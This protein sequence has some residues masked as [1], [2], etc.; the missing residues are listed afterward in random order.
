[1]SDSIKTYRIRTEVGNTHDAVIHVPLKQTYDMLEILSLKLDQSKSYK[2]YTS[3]YGVVVGR[4]QANDA[5]GI[6][7]CK[8]SVFIAYDEDNTDVKKSILYHYSSVQSTDN[9]GVR[10]NLLPD[11]L[12]EA[13]H[14]NVGTFPNKRLILDNKDELEIF[15]EYWKYTTVT[16]E[17]GDYMLYGVPT[18]SQQ[19]HI[20]VD[21]SDIGIWS[22]KPTDMVY[23]G[24]NINQF[25]SP[26][27]FK[28]SKNLNSLSQIYTQD[29]GLYVYPYWGETTENSDIIGITR[30]DINIDYKFEPTCIFMGSIIT[31]SGNNAIGK[32]CAGDKRLGKMANLTT[33]EG[34]IEMIRKTFDN[35]VEQIRIK[36]DRVINGD[37]VW[38][39]QIPMNLD[40][41]KTDEYGNLVPSDDPTKGIPTR[42]R[43][44]FRVSLDEQANDG[45]ARK[46]CKYLVPN[47]PHIDDEG[48]AEDKT[49]DYEFGSATREES[50]CDLFW[51]KVYSV[52][53]YIPRFQKKNKVTIRDHSGIKL[54]NHYG[55]GINP[56]PYN[57]LTIKLSFTY[58]LICVIVKIFI[59][60]IEFINTFLGILILPFCQICKTLKSLDKVPIIRRLVKPLRNLFCGISG[61]VKCIKISENFCDDG[62]NPN[63]Y[64][65]GC[66]GCIW[67][68]NTLPSCQKENSKKENEDKLQCLNS[69]EQLFNCVENDLAQDN[70]ATSFNFENDWVNGVLYAPLWYRRIRKKKKFFFGLFSR[71]AKDEWCSAD[72]TNSSLR[73]FKSCSPTRQ[74]DGTYKNFENEATP[75]YRIKGNSCTDN[76]KCHETVTQVS[77]IKGVIKQT[78]NILGKYIYYYSPAEYIIDNSN[79]KEDTK[80]HINRLFAT[81]IIL[82]GSLNE[83]DTDGIPQFFKNL[84]PTTYN[85]P[86]DIL[87]TDHEFKD[88]FDEKGEFVDT[89]YEEFSEAAGCDWGNKNEYG[90]SDGGLF[91]NIGCS[92]INLQTKS[93]V[94][95]SRICE[96][97]VALDESRQIPSLDQ[98]ESDENA[99]EYLRTDGFISYDELNNFDARSQFATLNG[100]RL[101]TVINTETGLKKYDFRFLYP[102]NFDGSLYE[103]MKDTTKNYDKKVNYKLNYNLEVKSVDYYKFRMGDKPYY[104]DTNHSFP[105]YENSFYF[106]FGL[107]DGKTA[108]EK[109]NSDFFADCETSGS[110]EVSIGIKTTPNSW[111]GEINKEYDGYVALDFSNISSP[112]SFTIDSMTDDSYPTISFTDVTDEKLILGGEYIDK[113]TEAYKKLI[114]NGYILKEDLGNNKKGINNGEYT[115]TVTDSE[116]EILTANFSMKSQAITFKLSTEDFKKDNTVLANTYNSNYCNI[117]N[118]GKGEAETSFDE[119]SNEV[120]RKMGGV[121]GIYDIFNGNDYLTDNFVLT[122]DTQT[123]IAYTYPSIKVKDGKVSVTGCGVLMQSKKDENGFRFLIGVPYGGISY[124]VTITQ[125]CGDDTS[126]NSTSSTV[127]ISE[128]IKYRL[129]INDVDVSVIEKGFKTGWAV[130][131]NSNNPSI[132]Q[133]GTLTGWLNISDP[134]NLN[135]YNDGQT[136]FDW[137]QNS[138]YKKETYGYEVVYKQDGVTIDEEATKESASNQSAILQEK[139]AR[140]NFI[141]EMK[142]TFYLT[143]TT[144]S[145]DLYFNVQTSSKPSDVAVVY[146]EEETKEDAEETYNVISCNGVTFSR[147]D[148]ISDIEIPTIAYV[149]DLTYGGGKVISGNAAYTLDSR[150]DCDNKAKP[151][152]FV[153]CVNGDGDTI[154]SSNVGTKKD[155]EQYIM[156]GTVNGYFGFHIIDKRFKSDYIAWAYMNNIPYYKPKDD[157]L[158]GLSVKMAGLFAGYLYNGT[159]SNVPSEE[160][161]MVTFDEQL[162]GTKAILIKNVDKSED[163][164]PTRR[165]M[166][167]NTILPYKNY[168][169]TNEITDNS[170]QYV[171]VSNKSLTLS[172]EETSGCYIDEDIYGNMKVTLLSSSVNNIKTKERKL[173]VSSNVS[174]TDDEITY[175]VINADSVEF[176]LNSVSIINYGNTQEYVAD[177]NSDTESWNNSVPLTMFNY[178]TT[179]SEISKK[180]DTNVSSYSN[181]ENSDNGGTTQKQS[182]GYGSSGYFSNISEKGAYYIIAVTNNSLRAISSVYNYPDLEGF[183]TFGTY[184]SKV[185][186]D[187]QKDEETGKETI[188]YKN[189]ETKKIGFGINNISDDTYY[190]KYF[191]YDLSVLLTISDISKI[192]ASD[193]VQGGADNVLY[194]ELNDNNFKTITTWYKNKLTRVITI[195]RR[196]TFTATDCTGLKHIFGVNSF[197]QENKY[198]VTWKLNNDNAQWY[199]DQ[200][201]AFTEDIDKAYLTDKTY[202]LNDCFH[203]GKE[204]TS[205]DGGSLVGWS[206]DKSTTWE[207][208]Y[209]EIYHKVDDEITDK[210]AQIWYGIWKVIIA[211]IYHVY[212]EDTDGMW[213]DE[214]IEDIKIECDAEHKAK[215]DEEMTEKYMKP[216]SKT[217]TTLM[218]EK[219]VCDDEDVTID[220]DG[221]VTTE[222]TCTLYPNWIHI[223]VKADTNHLLVSGDG[224]TDDDYTHL[225]YYL[226]G[227]NGKYYSEDVILEEVPL[228]DD[229]LKIQFTEIE[230]KVTED[231]KNAKVI[232]IKENDVNK[233]RYYRFRAKYNVYGTYSDIVEIR[234]VGK[235]QIILPDFDYLTFTYNWSGND[236][237]DLDSATTMR[238]TGIPITDTTT[239]EDYYVGYGGIT[240]STSPPYADKVREYIQHGGDNTSSGDEG[241]LINWKKICA[242]KDYVSEGITTLYCDIYANWYNVKKNGNLIIS[243]KT[244]KGDSGMTLDKDKHIFIPND[245]TVIVSDGVKTDKIYVNAHGNPNVCND[246]DLVKRFYSKVATLEYYIKTKVA[247]LNAYYDSEESGGRSLTEFAVTIDGQYFKE[248]KSTQKFLVEKKN[249][250]STEQTY[251]FTIS[252]FSYNENGTKKILK[253]KEDIISF[254]QTYYIIDENG[255]PKHDTATGNWCSVTYNFDDDGNI[256]VSYNITSNETEYERECDIEFYV[257]KSEKTNYIN[258]NYLYNIYQLK[259]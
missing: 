157:T 208:E 201:G 21:L 53:N 142:D 2:Y 94:N 255:K 159:P 212:D 169:V 233:D 70:E 20:D 195:N 10:Y 197:K 90:K 22:Q 46:R 171:Q 17:S 250:P 26:T 202:K 211:V 76:K 111:C 186:D 240:P 44:R 60:I 235:E 101:K 58:R 114:E 41:V 126:N 234:Q 7:N 118:A 203:N 83:C 64:Y 144:D 32:N 78:T 88:N 40:Y 226:S 141:T 185:E 131:G 229:M 4:V 174:L 223:E 43:V 72:G 25:D 173:N 87:F 150:C 151:P 168:I 24:Y 154:P 225:Y 199:T 129:F 85:L 69:T 73:L 177:L 241:A 54:I 37:G 103:I 135:D 172:I 179:E 39:Y 18:G 31:D 79:T 136:L 68:T 146:K 81:D 93:C 166:Y 125:L 122:I 181:V 128:P 175:Y 156:D 138:K 204:P 252:E 182:N 112:Y 143:C 194:A 189:V 74:Q 140:K 121:I 14:Q 61:A 42:A 120:N 216:R 134:N 139:E 132:K 127:K 242:Y 19:L 29:R 214:S 33:G 57:N 100:N 16:N 253:N 224:D 8:V 124:I 56:M 36:G 196:T 215:M 123:K 152:Y 62:V 222:H 158:Y 198:V 99:Y 35:K 259:Q 162:L 65:P 50:Y 116:G 71:K 228:D 119:T 230:T 167:D 147:T 176:P 193:T 113:E 5:V 207:D 27:K 11:E 115:I 247:I 1:M 184:T 102:E 86:S 23:K 105:R 6:P 92:T 218:F 187:V 160:D 220:E 180:C 28:T 84:D 109:F 221:T 191:S 67:K 206:T 89:E 248:D 98:L 192:E 63:V 178:L 77:M 106:Y 254:R 190:F 13:C 149:N 9:D 45:Q 34:S 237:R 256:N 148:T 170:F 249:L 236:G 137:G 246:V 210:T 110:E 48:F 257:N 219:W 239:L 107:K 231:G 258:C 161:Y 232:K 238:N 59:F 49:P 227:D 245:G 97:G 75:Y 52:K 66:T 12:D 82:L 164:I 243:F 55:D 200:Y 133:S 47:N 213:K 30:C 251:S 3:D 188:T 95:L 91:Y 104:Y 244:Y 205:S 108:I 165:L 80:G 163:A 209:S 217:D 183:V 130:S 96:I 145:K 153:A 38:C 51:N 15:E 155:D 117:A